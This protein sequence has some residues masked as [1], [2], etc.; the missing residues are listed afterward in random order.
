MEWQSTGSKVQRDEGSP[1]NDEKIASL[2]Q[3]DFLLSAQYFGNLRKTLLEPEKKL[4]FAILEDAI[5]CYQSNLTAQSVRGKR[6]FE[7]T[8]NWIVAV[9]S[10]WIFSFENVCEALGLNPQYVRQGLLRW[11]EKYRQRHFD[12][13]AW[14][15]K[16]L[17]G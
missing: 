13:E 3:P 5:S 11:A 10:D 14:K 15:G 17:A 4:M 12:R 1:T 6:F 16:K 9:G 2:F 7:E 8:K